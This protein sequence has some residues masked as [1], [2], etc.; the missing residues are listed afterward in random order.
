[1]LICINPKCPSNCIFGD[2]VF[3]DGEINRDNLMLV[4]TEQFESSPEFNELHDAAVD[5]CMEIRAK[6]I[7]KFGGKMKD[8]K[9]DRT[10]GGFAMCLHRYY[11]NNCPEDVWEDCRF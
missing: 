9:C 8:G 7:E 2:D 5:H 3:V 10:K 11:F 6:M 1:M 4:I